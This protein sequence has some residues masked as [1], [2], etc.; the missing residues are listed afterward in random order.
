MLVITLVALSWTHYLDQHATES[1][2]QRFTRALAV[3][4]LARAF[5]GIIS[6]AQ[7]TE[8]AIQP[9]GVGVSLS[10]GEILDPLNDLVERFSALALI[11]SASL[12]LQL[13]IA[14]IL[15]T[16]GFSIVLTILALAYLLSLAWC[17][18]SQG[19]SSQPPAWQ[20]YLT[21]ALAVAIFLR[22][23][24]ALTLVLTHWVDSTFLNEMQSQA[25]AELARTSGNIKTIQNSQQ[26]SADVTEADGFFDRT[27]QGLSKLIQ[28][29]SQTLNAREHM[30]R[31][32]AEVEASIAEMINLIVV[33]LLQTL[34][35][36]A[37]SLYLCWWTLKS[38]WRRSANKPL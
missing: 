32:E 38:F 2:E 12:G 33:F 29:S 26:P 6:V 17:R 36:P 35:V 34:I 3:A 7:S 9:V 31:L 16:T 18:F 37:L 14:K 15:A 20:H 21:R 30:T 22:F 28:G 1:T 4:A 5:N 27:T 13:T 10:V 23:M 11:A 25:T 8:V 24:L 19:A